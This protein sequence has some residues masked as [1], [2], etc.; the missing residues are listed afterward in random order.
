MQHLTIFSLVQSSDLSSVFEIV[1][2]ALRNNALPAHEGTRIETSDENTGDSKPSGL[3]WDYEA[4]TLPCVKFRPLRE[5]P[6]EKK[7]KQL[8]MTLTLMPDED[9]Q[10]RCFHG[11][12]TDCAAGNKGSLGTISP[13]LLSLL[14]SQKDE[15]RP[16]VSKRN[17]VKH[18]IKES[19]EEFA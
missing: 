9:P 8:N 16:H 18:S 19:K 7:P 17:R 4:M 11:V 2:A 10:K 14:A 12:F 6:G 3:Q 15:P 1:A 5:G 13:E